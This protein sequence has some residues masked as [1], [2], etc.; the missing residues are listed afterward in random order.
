MGISFSKESIFIKL[1]RL[2]NCSDND[3]NKLSANSL[4]YLCSVGR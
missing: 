2:D 4:T 3:G 1:N